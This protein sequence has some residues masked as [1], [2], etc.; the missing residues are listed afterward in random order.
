MQILNKLFFL[1]ILLALN[2]VSCQSKMV[3]DSTSYKNL[4]SEKKQDVDEYLTDA[5]KMIPKKETEIILMFQYNCFFQ[6]KITIN[7]RY[8]KEFPKTDKIH[9]GQSTVNFSKKLGKIKI[10]LSNGKYFT[11]L[12]KKGYDYITICYNEQYETIYIHYYDFPKI[13]IEE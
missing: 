4:D 10:K 3:V 5:K 9:Y 7:N 6:K 11:I 13:L 8:T 12:Q 1:S 2:F